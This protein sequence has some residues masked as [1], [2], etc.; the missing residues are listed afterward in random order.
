MSKYHRLEGFSNRTCCL[1]V[2]SW[3]QD[4]SRLVSSEPLTGLQTATS[5]SEGSS[6]FPPFYRV[7]HWIGTP[8]ERPHL[9]QW[10][11][12]IHLH[13]LRSKSLEGDSLPVCSFISNLCLDIKPQTSPLPL[14]FS[15]LHLFWFVKPTSIGSAMP[16]NHLGVRTSELGLQNLIWPV[17]LSI[18]YPY[19]RLSDGMKQTMFSLDLGGNLLVPA[20]LWGYVRLTEALHSPGGYF[21]AHCNPTTEER[22]PN[23]AL[24]ASLSY[25]VLAH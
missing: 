19:T 20:K 15:V 23:I 4:G 5:P 12:K 14:N 24:Q 7:C 22:L 25:L 18:K 3:I 1:I 16:S 11:L 10:T 6:Q 17:T 9:T 8:K 2:L 13:T 21:S